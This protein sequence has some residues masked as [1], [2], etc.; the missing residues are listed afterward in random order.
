MLIISYDFS[1]D[2]TRRQFS[3]FLEKF[4]HRIQY[5]VFEIKDSPRVLQNILIS[6]ELKYKKKFTGS[7]SILIFQLC[8]GCVSKIKRYGYAK[9]EESD[10]ICIK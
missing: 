10:L 2:K 7:D 1:N 5:S 3:K 6:I 9:H 4:G 8:K